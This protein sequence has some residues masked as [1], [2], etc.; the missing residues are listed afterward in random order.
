MK[1]HCMCGP[2][3]W[4]MSRLSAEQRKKIEEIRGTLDTLRQ[5][6]EAVSPEEMD[7]FG[8]LYEAVQELKEAD[9]SLQ[10]VYVTSA[11]NY[12]PDFTPPPPLFTRGTPT[13]DVS[14]TSAG[15]RERPEPIPTIRHIC[16]NFICE[17]SDDDERR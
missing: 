2:I 6:L 8:S 3:W 9:A 11:P 12:M 1:W 10:S 7:R 5:D 13:V 15:E 17:R 16:Q 4:N 14:E